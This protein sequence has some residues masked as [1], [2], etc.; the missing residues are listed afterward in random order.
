[1]VLHKKN[2][3]G[4]NVN[5]DEL[6][7]EAAFAKKYYS[8]GCEYT[9]QGNLNRA[10]VA[11][12]LCL[13]C[14]PTNERAEYNLRRVTERNIQSSIN[15]NIGKIK[16]AKGDVKNATALF[17]EAKRLDPSNVEAWINLGS[18]YHSMNK[19]ESAILCNERA[20]SF[21]THNEIGRFNLGCCLR[22][23]EGSLVQALEMFETVLEL[24]PN[25]VYARYNIG[26]IRQQ[27][28]DYKQALDSYKQVLII[29]QNFDEA[30]TAIQSLVETF[31]LRN[32]NLESLT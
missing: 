32:G 13:Q 30:K 24:N 17:I 27:L 8:M 26:C 25:H 2:E 6:E 11:F 7:M 31:H 20:I 15:V 29:D 16:L 18:I 21:D 4:D 3:T 28:G 14:D 23:V 1:M 22:D 9:K 19:L 10:I 12:K 5:E